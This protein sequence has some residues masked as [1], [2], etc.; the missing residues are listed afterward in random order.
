SRSL[1]DRPDEWQVVDTHAEHDFDLRCTTIV[2]LPGGRARKSLVLTGS[3]RTYIFS[4]TAPGR[5]ELTLIE[6]SRLLPQW[7]D[8]ERIVDARIDR[9]AS[10]LM[11]LGNGGTLALYSWRANG[12]TGKLRQRLRIVPP[13]KYARPAGQGHQDYVFRA[14]SRWPG[15]LAVL[16][17]DHVTC[18]PY[19]FTNRGLPQFEDV[20]ELDA[21]WIRVP[22]AD[23]LTAWQPYRDGKRVAVF[24]GSATQGVSFLMWRIDGHPLD[25]VPR[26]VELPVIR[27]PRGV[28]FVTARSEEHDLD[29]PALLAVATRDHR[30][31]ITS[32]LDRKFVR[33]ALS[34]Q[35]PLLPSAYRSRRGVAFFRA[36]SG[37][38]A[39]QGRAATG[40]QPRLVEDEYDFST[41]EAA[42]L[43]RLGPA[44]VSALA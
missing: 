35:V 32:I 44:T 19:K 30:L 23:A 41:F 27:K 11:V 39:F 10:V 28:L 40:D 13:R 25:V 26:P 12:A 22:H 16:A 34:K 17:S 20:E 4:E 36:Q 15:G 9:S 37:I 38:N 29:R 33:D 2:P 6:A 14:L 43:I 8:N 5:S 31:I 24:V 18:I 1:R 7:D 3:P 42:D 21:R